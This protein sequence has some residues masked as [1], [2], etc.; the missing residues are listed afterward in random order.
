MEQLPAELSVAYFGNMRLVGSNLQLVKVLDDNTAY[1]RHEIR[2]K[3][4]GLTISG[5]LNIPKGEGPFP[6]LILNHGHIP[7]SIYTIGRG[8]KR[9]QDYLARQGFAVLHTDY[10]GHGASDPSP[11]TVRMA[12]DAGLE[13]SMDSVNAVLAMREAKIPGVDTE[14]VGMLGHSMGGGVSLNIATA[15]PDSVDA[16]VLYAPVHADAWENFMRWRSE[17]D[18]G[19]RT[20]ELLGTREENP[21]A[22]DALSSKTWIKDIEDPVLLFHGT[23]DKDVPIA[24]SEDLQQTMAAHGKAFRLVRYE[25]EGHEFGPQWNDFMRQT[26]AFFDE[27]L[28]PTPAAATS[29]YDPLRVTKKPFGIRIDPVTSPVQPERFSGYHTGADFEVLPGEEPETI[30]VSS[31]CEGLIAYSGSVNGYGGV[32]V[33][34]CRMNNEDVT[35]LYGHLSPASLAP[36]GTSLSLQEKIGVLG[37]AH[38][39]ETDGERAHLHLAIHRGS[40]VELRGYAAQESSLSEWIDPIPLLP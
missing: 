7:P 18:E 13:Y 19:D 32:V 23:N 27:H 40:A 17:R 37:A 4:N 35:V 3:S 30:A 8:L 36:K 6:L 33:Q 28:R 14:H 10:R 29:I 5:I 34:T 38:S 9:E 11:D 16:V 39:S 21:A 24:W 25:G 31:L 15:R 20:R 12:Y 1:T 2:Y 22:W 26:A